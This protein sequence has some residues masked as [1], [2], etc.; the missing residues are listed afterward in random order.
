MP[1]LHFDARIDTVVDDL[2][3][4]LSTRLVRSGKVADLT[5]RLALRVSVEDD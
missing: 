3:C 4:T 1:S 5:L 2:V